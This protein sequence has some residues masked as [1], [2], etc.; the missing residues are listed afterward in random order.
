[1]PLE[2]GVTARPGVRNGAVG[3][4]LHFTELHL[5]T[6]TEELQSEKLSKSWEV[7]YRE[8]AIFLEEGNTAITA[9]SYINIMVV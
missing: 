8:A 7:N 5:V 1:M 9:I 2:L 6:E 4:R 3:S